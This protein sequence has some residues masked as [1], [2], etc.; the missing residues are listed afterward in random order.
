MPP[1]TSARPLPVKA[2]P[3]HHR[4][5]QYQS[6][7]P[8]PA[9]A[10]P[11][12]VQVS[13]LDSTAVPEPSERAV[14]LDLSNLN[15]SSV[16]QGELLALL[17]QF[18]SAASKA[19]PGIEVHQGAQGASTSTAAF[20]AAAA[21]CESNAAAACIE[22]HQGAQGAAASTAAFGAEAAVCE[23]NAAAA[24]DVSAGVRGTSHPSV[25]AEPATVASPT[26]IAEP[27][28]QAG[29]S[30]SSP[31]TVTPALA[32]FQSQAWTPLSCPTD[33]PATAHA[34]VPGA[35]FK[36]QLLSLHLS[37]SCYLDLFLTL[38]TK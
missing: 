34:A 38:P 12:I 19:A 25:T 35:S 7:G 18:Q 4:E 32:Q 5:I 21:V 17:V 30:N 15:L 11:R 13:P 3:Q 20:G 9:K 36:S 2:M 31:S 27:A 1:P 6:I 37:R 23:S 24:S 16:S 8:P 28:A 22:G 14:H 33:D 29:I 10:P 26:P